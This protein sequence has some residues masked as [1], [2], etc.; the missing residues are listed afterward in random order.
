MAKP[1]IQSVKGMNDF[2]P[3]DQPYWHF[4]MKKAAAILS[5]YGF[6]KIDTPIVES[7]QLFVRSVGEAT[8]IVEK[9]MYNFK[10]KGGDEL[11]LRPEL[12]A[13]TLRAYIEHRMHVLPHP[14]RLWSQGPV[15]RH[16]NPL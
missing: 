8:D 5:D 12:T 13:G 7:T 3:A 1:S 10:T 2:F 9:E 6:E 11:S 15:F 4:I 16:D 14:I